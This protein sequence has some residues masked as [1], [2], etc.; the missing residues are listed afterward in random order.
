MTGRMSNR[1]RIAHAALEAEAERKAREK[2]AAER[3]ANPP[4]RA[5]APK[6]KATKPVGRTR[7]V[8]AVC[9]PSGS[10]IDTFPYPKEAEARA[11]AERLTAEKGRPHFVKRGEV[12][13]E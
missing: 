5:K 4:K 12:P 11:E 1:D 9:D 8:W 10:T 7:I 6:A 13:F 2:A 3:A